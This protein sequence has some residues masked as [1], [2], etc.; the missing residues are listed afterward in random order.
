MITKCTN[1]ETFKLK[2]QELR[3][4]YFNTDNV[5][6]INTNKLVNLICLRC[7][8]NFDIAPCVLFRKKKECC[9]KCNLL[10]P[11]KQRIKYKYSLEDYIIFA[12]SKNWKYLSKNI[13]QNITIPGGLFECEYG[14]PWNTSAL[15]DLKKG[16]GCPTCSNG[17]KK[18]LLDYQ[19]ICGNKG[20]YLDD[21]I[22]K[23]TE[24]NI[25]YF[26]YNCE[27]EYIS[28]YHNI[29]KGCWCNCK[30]LKTLNDYLNIGNNNVEYILDYIPIKTLVRINGWKC[31]ICN[32]IFTCSYISISVGSS[33]TCTIYKTQNKLKKKL[34][35]KYPDLI[36]EF[37]P[38]WIRNP[39][40]GWFLSF[41]FMIKMEGFKIIIE[42]DGIDHFSNSRGEDKTC[43]IQN[44]YRDIY[45]MKKSLE[46]GYYLIRL[47]QPDV[48]ADKNN[49]CEKF[50]NIL[51]N[52]EKGIYE[53]PEIIIVDNH[54]KYEN[55]IEDFNNY[56]NI[57]E[58]I[59]K[60]LY[61]FREWIELREEIDINIGKLNIN[62]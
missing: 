35:E 42:L 5:N 27:N 56:E 55:H 39:K 62:N 12:N 48:W 38:E 41:D 58:N 45:K 7:N 15:H 53:L 36:C 18:T 8:L 34:L 13:P 23:T 2:L 46:N 47:Y 19:K 21:I 40:T 4:D 22:P 30:N 57:E 51:N 32:E 61:S 14:H 11:R 49:W 3:P 10:V 6:Y 31:K 1:T 17:T 26:C 52:I 24:T 9:P 20:K 44:R 60:A 33:C 16:H 28:C 43:H 50:N 54:I 37:K 29:E 59:N 25:K